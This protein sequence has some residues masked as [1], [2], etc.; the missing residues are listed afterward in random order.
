[1]KVLVIEQDPRIRAMVSEFLWLRGH[2]I[3]AAP[4]AEEAWDAHAGE[5]YA[6]MVVDVDLPGMSGIEFCRR[7]RTLPDG[8]TCYIVVLTNKVDPKSLADL[9]DAGASDYVTKPLNLDLLQ[10]RLNV[11]ERHVAEIARRRAAED[12]LA[13]QSYHDS[14]TGLP[15]RTLLRD[16]LN[17]AILAAQRTYEPLALVV[18][19]LDRFADINDTLGHNAGDVVLQ[20]IGQRLHDE[21]RTSDT[22]ARLGG[23]EFAVVLRS[24]DDQGAKIVADRILQTLSAPF[25]VGDMNLDV[26]AS[27]GI[28]LYPFHG[29][30]ANTLIQRAD[31]AMYLAKQNRSGYAFYTSDRDEHSSSRLALMGDLRRAIEHDELVVYYQPKIACATGC[32]CGAEALVRW[33]HPEQGLLFPDKFIPLAEQSGL[34]TPLTLWVLKDVLRQIRAW[35]DQGMPLRVAVNLSARSLQDPE[36]PGDVAEALEL[37]G[38]DFSSLELEIT[39]SAVMADPVRALEIVSQLANLGIHL[40]IDDFGTGYSSLAYLKRL[41]V[42]NLK[43]DKSFVLEMLTNEND[44]T[45]VRSIINLGHDLGLKVIAEGVETAEIFNRLRELECDEA[46]GYYMSKPIPADAFARFAVE[47]QWSITQP[48]SPASS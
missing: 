22:V 45:I 25:T 28:A 35:D 12:E 9:I 37:A 5:P 42:K 1:V 4:D 29:T 18:M 23:D 34:M 41:P 30:D 40:S 43:I 16:R 48:V 8:D 7:I 14:L 3:A 27:I 39:E 46:Q 11:A 2:Q 38:V 32:V 6:F 33:Q 44:G 26:E 36:L 17:Q 13:H 19:D 15:N 10:V 47:S 20:Q 31:V 24:A 21:L